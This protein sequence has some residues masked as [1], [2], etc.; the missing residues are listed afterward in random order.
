MP[1]NNDYTITLGNVKYYINGN[2]Q[3]REIIQMH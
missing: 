1:N 3:Q 2:K